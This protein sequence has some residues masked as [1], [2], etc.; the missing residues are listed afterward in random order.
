VFV[1]LSLEMLSDRPESRS[2][3][4]SEELGALLKHAFVIN[5]A[6]GG[7]IDEFAL[8][9]ALTSGQIAGAALDSL[10]PGATALG[11]TPSSLSRT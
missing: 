9:D 3:I 2:L 4:G 10:R 11:P 7:I 8:Y 6:R 5:A 1:R